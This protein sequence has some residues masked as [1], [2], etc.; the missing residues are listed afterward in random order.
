MR[1]LVWRAFSTDFPLAA[2]TKLIDTV[3]SV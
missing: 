2:I 1:V 3:K